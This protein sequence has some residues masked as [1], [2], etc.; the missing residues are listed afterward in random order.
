MRPFTGVRHVLLAPTF[1]QAVDVHAKGLETLLSC[2]WAFLGGVINRTRWRVEFPG[3]SWIQFFGAENADAA[4]GIRCDGVTL[5]ECDDIGK[6]VFDAVVTPWL[7]EP[8]SL[9][10][11]LA[12]GTPRRGRMGLLYKL[13]SEGRGPNKLPESWSFHATYRDA[14]ENVDVHVIDTK[15][16][17]MDPAL[18]A[19]EYEA[20]FE[21]G[22][23]L[24]FPMFD[25]AFHVRKPPVGMQF[26]RYLI[27]GDWGF[28]DAGVLVVIGLTGH[29]SDTV[30]HVIHEV[31]ETQRT[32]SWWIDEVRKLHS[33]FPE[34]R[35]YYEHRPEFIEEVKR[36][37]GLRIEP[38][39]KARGL[40]VQM[41]ADALVIHDDGE[42]HRWSQL[43]VDP[44]CTNLIREFGLY[45]YRRDPHDREHFLDD[46][47]DS[48]ND[49]AIDSCRYALYSEFGG[50]DRRVFGG[51]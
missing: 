24:V 9:K 12:G 31:Y 8:W 48:K 22:Q 32:Q 13:F 33:A 46:I 29:G 43:Y 49:H 3:G 39:D 44:A 15:R 11:T 40:G 38:A 28:V 30:A 41:L 37:T 10:M 19:R 26:D 20:S 27:G 1:K 34:A 2:E 7:S 17:S 36:S 18:F 14:P 47:D 25:A 16:R 4:R 6:N 23:G 50:P 21:S 5:D 35:W 51:R 45:S 42:G